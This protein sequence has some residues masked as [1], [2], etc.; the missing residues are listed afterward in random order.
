VI[1]G[2]DY[3][4]SVP[5]VTWNREAERDLDQQLRQRCATACCSHTALLMTEWLD[6]ALHGDS[7][8]RDVPTREVWISLLEEVRGRVQR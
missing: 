7:V 5:S 2:V 8:A 6:R 4:A 3:S 1:L